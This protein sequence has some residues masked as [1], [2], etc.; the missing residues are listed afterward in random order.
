MA[1]ALRL[2]AV[3]ALSAAS[4]CNGG[5]T[6][7]SQTISLQIFGDAAEIK[8]YKD[9]IAAFDRKQTGIRVQLI[10]VPSQSDH[11]AKL[12]SGFA[13]GKP[14][15]LFLINYRR[16]GQYAGQGVLENMGP[17]LDRSASLMKADFY[18]QAMDA[19]A[20]GGRQAC[21]PQNISSL[22]VYYNR[23]LFKRFG[24][25]EPKAGWTW[26]DFLATAKSLTRDTN[27]DRKTDV[28]GL[29]VEPNLIRMAPFVWQAGAE[30]VTDTLS[31]DKTAML[32]GKALEALRFFIELRRVHHVVPEQDEAKSEDDEARFAR[33]TMAMFMDSRRAVTTLRATARLDWDVAPLPRKRRAATILHSDAYCMSKASKVKDA[34]FRFVEFALGPEGAPIIARTG[35][36]VPSLR[37]VAESEAFLSPGQRPAG[38]RVFLDA[39][40]TIRRLPNIATWNEIETKANP[41]I[42]EWFYGPERI[43]ALGIEID[44]ATRELFGERAQTSG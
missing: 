12:S 11:A 27:G 19:F 36:T 6:A 28:F 4:A 39:V 29:G 35:R 33:G 20:F 25:A 9:L 32:D 18:E 17:R 42:E 44:L 23:A 22:V 8:A 30:V 15:D 21:L 24:V 2:L 34:A 1:R 38:A 43:E 14:P 10:S 31:P 16:F 26:Q 13:G 40:P 5:G 37:S 3:L 41:I 7:G